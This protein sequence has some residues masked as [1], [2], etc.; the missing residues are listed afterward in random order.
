MSRPPNLKKSFHLRVYAQLN[1][2][3]SPERKQKTFLATF[4]PPITVQEIILTLGIPLSE[5]HLV[6][7]NNEKVPFSHFPKTNDRIAIFPEFIQLPL[8]NKPED[9]TPKETTFILDAHLG[10]LAKYLRMLGFDTLYDNHFKDEEILNTAASNGRIILTRDKALLTSPKIQAGYFVRAI[11]P[12]AQLQ[13]VVK[14]FD[15]SPHFKSFT[16]CMTCNSPLHQVSAKEIAAKVPMT[17]AKVFDVFF[18]C[19]HCDKVFWKGSHFKRM[20]KFIRDLANT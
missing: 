10:K 5:V 15:L 13:E 11:H 16:R 7:V 6:L 12:H 2:F 9:A 18:Y 4:K 8:K 20:E 19:P 1:D 3:L 17:V 14:N